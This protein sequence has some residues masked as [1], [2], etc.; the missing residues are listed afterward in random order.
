VDETGLGSCPLAGSS[1]SCVQILGSAT[2]CQRV[3]STI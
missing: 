2:Q 1:I 3:N